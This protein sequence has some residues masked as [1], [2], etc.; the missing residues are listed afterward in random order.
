[1]FR[2]GLVLIFLLFSIDFTVVAFL[3]AVLSSTIKKAKNDSEKKKIDFTDLIYIL[4]PFMGV[5]GQSLCLNA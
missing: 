5:D 4:Y 1:M 3:S 2:I